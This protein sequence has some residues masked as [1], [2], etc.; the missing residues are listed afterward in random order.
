M[1]LKTQSSSRIKK[2]VQ[3]D[4]SLNHYRQLAREIMTHDNI[5]QTKKIERNVDKTLLSNEKIFYILQE[6]ICKV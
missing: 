4:V 2:S 5:F 6:N 3:H 1:S